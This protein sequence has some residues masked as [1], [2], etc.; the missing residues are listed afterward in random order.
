M[1]NRDVMLNINKCFA[2]LTAENRDC[3]SA[4]IVIVIERKQIDS[5]RMCKFSTDAQWLHVQLMRR[6]C[7]DDQE[8]EYR[9]DMFSIQDN[10]G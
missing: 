10:V 8:T 1:N 6:M 5:L 7:Q 9:S 3:P 4:I 2:P